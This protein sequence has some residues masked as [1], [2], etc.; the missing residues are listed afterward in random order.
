M[1]IALPLVLG[2]LEPGFPKVGVAGSLIAEEFASGTVS[3]WLSKPDEALLPGSA[4]A[5]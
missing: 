5:S 3:D 2:E 4:V 1:S